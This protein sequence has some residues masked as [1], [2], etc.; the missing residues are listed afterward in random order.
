V[1]R[2]INGEMETRGPV[3]MNQISEFHLSFYCRHFL[4]YYA[5]LWD[6]MSLV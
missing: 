1:D 6:L 3:A 2:V 4:C 5:F